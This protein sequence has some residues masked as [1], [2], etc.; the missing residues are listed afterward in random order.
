M[1]ARQEEIERRVKKKKY[2]VIGNQPP[3]KATAD[4]VGNRFKVQ[5]REQSVE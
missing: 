5:R 4:K 3:P 2:S 1:V